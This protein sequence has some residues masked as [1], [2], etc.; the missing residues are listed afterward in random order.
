M[1]VIDVLDS[2]MHYVELGSGKPVVF[3]HGNPASS[4]MWREVLPLVSGHRLIAPD[5]IGMGASGKPDLAYSFA[6]HARYL[7]EFLDALGLDDVVFVG[8]DWGG[9][10][11][12]DYAARHPGR[13]SAVAFFEAMVRPVG[14]AELSD[15]ARARFAMLRSAEG[16]AR[17]LDSTFLITTAYTGGV[18]TP[19]TEEEIAPYLAPYPSRESRRPLLAWA[20]SMPV[21]GDPADVAARLNAG[22][23]WLRTTPEIPKLLLTFD[24]SPTLLI[25]P[26][27]A[28][29]CKDNIPSLTITH[30]GPAGHHAA[31]DQPAP[32]ATALT[33]WLPL[34]P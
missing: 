17:A 33:T 14:P 21:D 16:E 26:A 1:P 32:I 11:A 28:A 5:L 6:D 23:D 15:Q 30:C 22:A 18:R 4:Y 10:L 3:L 20:R 27:L 13:V 19:L 12:F 25:T 34:L 24:S 7:E 29:W 8:H 31:E 2:T 9:A